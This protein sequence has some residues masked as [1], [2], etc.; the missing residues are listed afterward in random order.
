MDENEEGVACAADGPECD[1]WAIVDFGQGPVEVRC[2]VNHKEHPDFEEHICQ[3]VFED[4]DLDP[5]E[6]AGIVNPKMN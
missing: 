4:D 1:R 2:T 3:V 6:V 5:V